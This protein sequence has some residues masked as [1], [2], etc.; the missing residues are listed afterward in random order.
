[1]YLLSRLWLY[2]VINVMELKLIE[3][4]LLPLLLLLQ[5][6]PLVVGFNFFLC[7]IFLI[8]NIVISDNMSICF[9]PLFSSLH[10]SNTF[11]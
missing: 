10:H 7:L 8:S 11:T 5:L 4:L 2:K 3:K 1:M 6:L 9:S